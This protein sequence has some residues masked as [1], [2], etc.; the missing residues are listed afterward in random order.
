MTYTANFRTAIAPKPDA[1]LQLTYEHRL[2]LIG[3]CFA[4]NIGQRLEAR[5]WQVKLNPFG[6]VYNP[7][8]IA[9]SLQRLANPLPYTAADLFWHDHLWHS[10]DHHSRFAHADPQH[11]LQLIHSELTQAANHLAKAQ[12]LVLTYGTAYVYTYKPTQKVVANCHK[13]PASVFEK[14]LCSVSEI[15]AATLPA[16]QY[17]Q[18]QYPQ[19][20]IVFTISPVRHWRDGAVENQL[21]KAHLCLAL[22]ELCAQLP[23]THYFPA[24]ELMMDDL[25]DYR[26]Y[27]AD[28][29]HPNETAIE[30]IWQHF[31]QTY[32]APEAKKLMG[33]IETLL[34]AAQHRPR[35]PDSPAHA[36]FLQTYF[37]LATQLQHQY[38]Y[39]DFAP[40]I[41]YFGSKQP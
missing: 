17:L 19:L 30:Y 18:Q 20:H 9:E 25:R 24:Y 40:E 27:A 4:E 10:F 5:K 22:H 38:T 39:L 7:I 12:M 41:A 8:S 1:D 14:R 13:M 36:Q 31:V 34:S 11:C 26:F 33:D 35:Q 2:L 28:M 15:V 37:Q 32:C 29:L 16:L 23:Q 21:S 6:I 3:S